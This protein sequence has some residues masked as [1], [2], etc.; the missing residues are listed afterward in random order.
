MDSD[1]LNERLLARESA[2]P[3]QIMTFPSLNSVVSHC[4]AT[5]KIE[6]NTVTAVKFYGRDALNA[7]VFLYKNTVGYLNYLIFAIR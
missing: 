7:L 1:T 6:V 3:T 2:N 5:K 4:P